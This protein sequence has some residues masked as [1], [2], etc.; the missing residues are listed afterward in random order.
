V[1]FGLCPATGKRTAHFTV[2]N[3]LPIDQSLVCVIKDSPFKSW[4]SLDASQFSMKARETIHVKVKLTAFQDADATAKILIV[5]QNQIF[6]VKLMASCRSSLLVLDQKLDFGFI[7]IYHDGS[8]KTLA[9]YNQNKNQSLPVGYESSCDELLVNDGM[10]ILISPGSS[11]IV[12]V[13]FTSAYSGHRAESLVFFAP[14]SDP[15]KLEVLAFS[16]PPLLVPVQDDIFLP[17][18]S[19]DCPSSALFPISNI[20]QGPIQFTVTTPAG[21]CIRMALA[22][23]DKFNRK[24][25]TGAIK[26]EHKSV[27][28]SGGVGLIITLN[29]LVTLGLEVFFAPLKHECTRVPLEITVL[30]PKRSF[31]KLLYLNCIG[32]EDLALKESLNAAL[33]AERKFSRNPG[34]ISLFSGDPSKK[35]YAMDGSRKLKKQTTNVFQL[36]PPS[37]LV[38]GSYLEKKLN[39]DIYEYVTLSNN[40]AQAQKYH[41]IITEHFVTDI[42]LDGILP[43]SS[44]I[45]IP[46]RLNTYFF[47]MGVGIN[48]ENEQYAAVGSLAVIDDGT[49]GRA[50]FASVGLCGIMA[51]LVGLE[52]RGYAAK[53]QFPYGLESQQVTKRLILRNRCPENIVWEGGICSE[54]QFVLVRKVANYAEASPFI[55]SAVR[56]NLKPFESLELEVTFASA[57]S[58]KAKHNICMEYR[59]TFEH[60]GNDDKSVM[61][62]SR[63]LEPI[64]LEGS[65][66]KSSITSSLE[67]MWLSDTSPGAV[68]SIPLPMKNEGTGQANGIIQEIYPFSVSSARF[69]LN[70]ATFKEAKL[71]FTPL[72]CGVHSAPISLTDRNSQLFF[73]ACGIGGFCH[74]STSFGTAMFLH[75]HEK[76]TDN[77]YDV[78]TVGMGLR[79]KH[80]FELKNTGTLDL[81]ILSI[82]ANNSSDSGSIVRFGSPD[83]VQ[84]SSIKTNDK[85]RCVESLDFT[86]THKPIGRSLQRLGNEKVESVS[87][88]TLPMFPLRLPALKSL[89]LYCEVTGNILV[90][91]IV[92]I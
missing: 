9:L 85:F 86:D 21:S 18:A 43:A 4:F 77:V 29:P 73:F 87:V 65:I 35:V 6:T 20:S 25:S 49:N 64:L 42:P 31:A 24:P 19:P 1:D 57:V 44:S 70:P 81:V 58:G 76:R 14:A 62:R 27:D 47:T 74:V 51:D 79:R 13:K 66:G 2:E 56:V 72:T 91:L 78:G 11:L 84:A 67:H 34:R 7:D 61:E 90:S 46:L 10:P 92:H 8:T 82:V 22:D 40:T 30:K 50:G 52:V 28:F 71:K 83:V 33:I 37:V 45:Q 36:D 39:Q 23:P 53:I 55:L 38:F 15:I 60:G 88:A 3:L 26:I 59:D 80:V 54:D 41:L 12:P 89:K 5:G 69:S 63:A 17:L 16:G 68:G 75:D 48:Q 32:V